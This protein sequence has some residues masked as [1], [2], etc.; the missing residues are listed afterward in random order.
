MSTYQD[1]GGARER[2]ER[3]AGGSYTPGGEHPSMPWPEPQPLPSDQAERLE[4][5]LDALPPVM[6]GAVTAYQRFGQQSVAM[7]ATSALATA[8]LVCQGLADIERDQGL[9][10]PISL[11]AITIAQSGERKTGLDA[12]MSRAPRAWERDKRKELASK[13]KEAR[14]TRK[15]WEAR[16]SGIES[17][18][19]RLGGKTKP[20]D[21]ADRRLLEEKL[22]ELA[23]AEP[24]V[25]VDIALF[26]SDVTTDALRIQ[27]AYGWPSCALWADEAATVV[28]SHAFND[29]SAMRSFGL[30]NKL[31]DRNDAPLTDHRVGRAG[32]EIDG[33]RITCNLML[34]RDIFDALASV[35]DGLARGVG[36]LARFLICEP[37]STIG[38][39]AYIRPA[40][41][42]PELLAWD[43]RLT[44]LLD[45]DLPVR[46][47]DDPG[48][49]LAPP[50]LRLD[51]AAFELWV[52]Y[53]DAVEAQLRPAG[54]FSGLKDF[55]SKSAEQAAR[56][57]AIFHVMQHGPTGSISATTMHGAVRV[58]AW[59]LAET[60]RVLGMH[61]PAERVEDAAELLKWLAGRETPPSLKEVLQF[62]P[63][64][65]RKPKPRDAAIKLLAD[66]ALARLEDHAGTK[67]LV[68]SPRLS[69]LGD[70]KEAA[71]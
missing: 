10:G 36:A 64:R 37:A 4:F 70:E 30:L 35:K 34:Q 19:K 47:P 66:H 49:A 27:L 65:V 38:S 63:R 5:P 57:A 50:V 15:A 28:G 68:I 32:T 3:G 69:E 43:R 45:M 51:T 26:L 48:M 2:A 14:A 71:A 25:P 21:E 53:F 23:G 11:N 9:A 39:R 8:S 16:C 44:E 52:K 31:W 62:A 20:E 18:L 56:I 61:I 7:V 1:R 59:Y 40:D 24:P 58:S 42:A 13:I 17:D 60:R 46:D 22:V 6:Q 41:D 33:R 55:A 54:E 29:D 12:R 67:R